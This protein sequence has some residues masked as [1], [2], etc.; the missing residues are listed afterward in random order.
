MSRVNIYII[1]IKNQNIITNRQTDKE[2]LT[3]FFL[4]EYWLISKF[5]SETF[6]NKLEVRTLRAR[7]GNSKSVTYKNKQHKQNRTIYFKYNNTI[8]NMILYFSVLCSIV[9]YYT[10]QICP[11]RTDKQTENSN[12]EATLILCGSSGKRV[13]IIKWNFVLHE[14]I[15]EY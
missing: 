1:D 10:V 12:S 9:L 7:S 13:N 4:S 8:N 5:S 14:N 2:K 3:E 15:R 6:L 11:Q